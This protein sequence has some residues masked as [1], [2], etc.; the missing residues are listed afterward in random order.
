MTIVGTRRMI[1]YD[2]LQQR[3]KIRV[4]WYDVRGGNDRP[5][6]YLRGIPL[7][8]SL[9]RQLHS[10]IDQE[11]RQDRV[12]ALYRLHRDMAATVDRWPRRS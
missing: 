10:Y 4:V 11:D 3:E 7:F 8:I 9:R 5:I 12:S 6:T 2:D 1:V